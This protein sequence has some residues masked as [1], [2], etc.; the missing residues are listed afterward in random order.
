[1]LVF[2]LCTCILG[3]FILRWR[4]ESLS[5]YFG[6]RGSEPG[7]FMYALGNLSVWVVGGL[8]HWGSLV[9]LLF[10]DG[11][12]WAG[13]GFILAM[14]L[15]RPIFLLLCGKSR[16]E[17]RHNPQA[18]AP[19]AKRESQGTRLK[20]GLDRL[21]GG[22]SVESAIA[23]LLSASNKP[24]TMFVTE[25]WIQPRLQLLS[26]GLSNPITSD[27]ALAL[28]DAILQKCPFKNVLDWLGG[29]PMPWLDYQN[30][31]RALEARAKQE[32]AERIRNN[33]NPE[34]ARRLM[35]QGINVHIP[36][37]VL[38]RRKEKKDPGSQ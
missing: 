8:A 25:R 34:H 32:R 28:V 3:S 4:R 17:L 9:A 12:V 10:L 26:A 21:R 16:A 23:I 13:A 36:P 2:L 15:Q 24:D 22:I 27:Q 5:G 37:E 7:I 30:H 31:K 38:L 29:E 18:T 14:V 11:W 1:M 19:Q 20:Y 35:E 6:P 33:W